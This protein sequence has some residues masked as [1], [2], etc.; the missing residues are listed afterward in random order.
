MRNYTKIT[1]SLCIGLAMGMG[2]AMAGAKPDEIARLSADLTPIGS[3]RAG[4][5][6][7]TIP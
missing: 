2:Q 4:N 5:A 3:E 7:G 1:L 6:A